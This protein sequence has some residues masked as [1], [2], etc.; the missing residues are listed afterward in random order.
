MSL[1]AVAMPRMAQPPGSNQP[2]VQRDKV[3]E[4]T[5]QTWL[6]NSLV[7]ITG[8]GASVVLQRA[9]SAATVIY[10]L[11]PQAAAGSGTADALVVPPAFL[12]GRYH[13]PFDLRDV[14]LEI[15]ATNGSASG[16]NIGAN[17]VTWA[18][19]G[20]GGVALAPGQQYGLLT[21]TS[22]TY[23]K[24][25]TLDVTNTTQ[26]VFEI[27]RL[28]PGMLTSDNNP[29]LWVKVIPTALQG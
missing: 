2:F 23:D 15:T 29:R 21:M 7:Q 27:V 13:Y 4:G 28:A 25:Q 1:I 6:K 8:T 16:A 9:A 3:L 17:G 5:T 18:G 22:G 14:I 12:F 19:G 11:A 10:G 20:T 24:Y 26:K